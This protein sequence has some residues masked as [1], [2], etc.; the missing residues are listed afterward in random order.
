MP[1]HNF[2]DE[3]R[4]DPEIDAAKALLNRMRKLAEERGDSGLDAASLDKVRKRQ[5]SS[6]SLGSA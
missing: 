6:Y 3:H 5:L 1:S 4:L 2:D